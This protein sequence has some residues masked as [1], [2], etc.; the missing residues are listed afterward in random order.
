MWLSALALFVVLGAANLHFGDLNQ[1][2]GWYLYAARQVHDGG[3]PYRD[4][5]FTQGPMLPLVYSL[6][7]PLVERWGVAGGRL[8]TLL[9]GFVGAMM[10][11]W[12]AARAAPEGRKCVAALLAFT[13]I[14]G[15]VYQSYY[16]TIVKTYSLC[17]L[18]LVGGLLALSYAKSR[19]GWL[20][21]FVSGILLALSAGTRLSAGVA[22][23]IAGLYLLLM[24]RSFGDS[25]WLSFGVG[26]L[27]GLAAISAPFLKI[28]PES[29]LFCNFEYH[30]LR[31]AGG[32][33]P[34]LVYKAGF[35]SRFVQAYFLPACLAAAVV[36]FRWLKPE[37]A[38]AQPSDRLN[39]VLWAAGLAVTLVHL[40]APFPY[41]D[42]QVMVYPVLAAALA[43]SLV[44]SF[45]P[46]ADPPA[47]GKF[48]VSD[49]W[50]LWLLLFV[51][52]ASVASAFSSPVNQS[53][54][55]SGR[56][57][58]WWKVKEQTQLQRLREVGIW[59]S[60]QMGMDDLLL[61]QDTYLAVE[62]NLRVPKGMEMGPFSYYPEMSRERA[63]KIHVL[64]RDMML[65]LLE[66]TEA[67]IAA[68]S[69]YGLS[70]QSPQ[71]SEMSRD[72]RESLWDVVE[73]R[74]EEIYEVPDFG[75][76]FT[77][78]RIFRLRTDTK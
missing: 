31:S 28:A 66:K 21:C 24:R 72:D 46:K 43:G 62:A 78:L 38:E 75:Q 20:A 68:F 59:I 8:F 7:H 61:T 11:A 55:I 1:D 63:E 32:L 58:I 9:L 52:V 48:Q 40:S 65:E 3:L 74:Y 12:L 27:L 35:I 22:M 47:A 44:S 64:N 19:A 42:Y 69:G 73:K 54:M 41:E 56:D 36:L 6:A 25:R 67:P 13:L 49:R 53:W 18:F 2:E 34:A 50:T 14:A 39:V 23:P 60:E 10:A 17:A 15:N 71:V 16:T 29:F 5:A 37:P 45:P 77:T 33:V 70:I 51:F 76:A 30:S 4:F 57:R 26:G